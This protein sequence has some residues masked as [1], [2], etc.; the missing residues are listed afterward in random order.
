MRTR[1]L[2]AV[3]CLLTVMAV[4]F[5]TSEAQ[6]RPPITSPDVQD[7][8]SV[9]LRLDAP[10]AQKVSVNA[11]VI[12]SILDQSN[13]D[14]TKDENGIWSI[15]LGPLPPGIYDYSFNVD[16]LTI[17][18]PSSEH[19]FGNRRGSRGYLEIPGPA[20]QPRHDEWRNVPHG[21]VTAHW[22]KSAPADGSL[23]RL[24]VYTPPGYFQDTTK[25]YPV[26][27][28]LHG[29]GDNDSHWS[30]L[31]QANVI[32]D[33][34]FADGKAEPMLIVMPDGHPQIPAVENEER[35]ARY[36][37]SREVFENDVLEEIIPLIESNY[38]VKT[39]RMNRAIVGLSM[40]GG[41]SL[42][43][44]L[45]NVD[46][47]AWIGGFSSSARGLDD[48]VAKLGEDPEKTNELIQLLWIA[49]GKDD[50]L[51]EQNHTF[52]E[53][54]KKNKIEYEYKETEGSHTWNVWRLYLSEFIPLLFK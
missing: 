3:L 38:R 37:R 6:R 32:A 9:I 16:G 25:K 54:L 36:Y 35:G 12:K 50:F 20:N 2:Y 11:G 7:D 26:L 43:V 52:I 53:S 45:K 28:L 5:Q 15:K 46:K 33:N 23:R 44:G 27:Y 30:I 40:G 4:G 51:L 1:I 10:N 18:D 8:G 47:F 24:H 17:T 13:M 39:D 21:A 29:S 22:Y 41:Q 14:M 49:I 31:G 34:L 48:A 42:S 19:V